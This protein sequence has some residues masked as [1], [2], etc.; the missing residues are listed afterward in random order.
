MHRRTLLLGAAAAPLARPA[1][2]AQT[3]TLKMIPQV[4][5]NSI[6]PIWTSSQIARN[7]GFMVFDM[8]YGRDEAQNPQFQMVEADLMEDNAKTWTLRLRDG[9]LWHD[10]DK[11]LARDCVASLRRWMKRNAVGGALEERID[12][13]DAIDD[14]TLKFRLN[15]PYPHLRMVL[16]QF[17]IPPLMMPERLARTDPFKQIPEAIGSGPFRWLPD[18]HVLGSHCAFARFDKYVPR[19]EPPSYTAGGHVALLD[20]VEWKMIPDPQTAANALITGEVDWMEIPLPDLLPLL[21]KSR[22]VVTGNL[23]PYGQIL[24]LRPN[25]T[26]PPTSSKAIRHVMMAA[27]DQK[28][29]MAAVMGGDPDNA[30]TPIGFLSTGKPEV[31]NAGMD[32]VRAHHTP[33]QLKAMLEKA[34]YRGERLV[35]LHPTD[36]IYYNPTT[37]IVTQMLREAGFNIDDQLMDWATVQARRTSREP[38]DKGGWSLFCTVVTVADYRSP[39]LA[40]FIRGNGPKGW[41]GWPTDERMEQLYA[42]WLE[43]TDPA[44]QTRLEREYQLQAFDFL[45]FIPLGRYLQTSAWRDNVRGILKGPSAVFWNIDKV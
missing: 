8:L 13:L 40:A 34:G 10:G 43:T 24:F 14:R 4:A 30:I 1:I 7:M 20:R 31:D 44:E 6:D 35:M 45:P 37:S 16:S 9:L 21:K 23:D 41:F 12:S 3:K 39:L 2:G 11:V 28:E 17:I 42:T 36:H 38:L 25:H 27:I 22:G 32:E 15:K 5:L 33:A 18:E 26:L 19:E 29:V